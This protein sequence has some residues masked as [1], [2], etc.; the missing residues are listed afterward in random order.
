MKKT[1][2]TMDTKQLPTKN[3]LM[4]IKNTIRQ[5]KEGQTLL[6]QKRMIL[7]RE[8]EKYKEDE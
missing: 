2:G 4:K 3:N 6:E 1:G 7:K 8:L 5:S